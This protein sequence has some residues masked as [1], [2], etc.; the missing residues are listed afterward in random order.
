MMVA[1]A[2]GDER[3]SDSR[4]PV[5]LYTCS[6]PALPSGTA[7]I[8]LASPLHDHAS[9]PECP[10]CATV[11]DIRAKLFDLLQTNPDVA[12]VAV[13]ASAL[14][15]L[16]ATIDRL[17]GAAPATALRDHTIARRFSFAGLVG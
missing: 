15:D 13:D 14:P 1:F 5:T 9:G 4:I 8:R 10:A 2:S 12:A 17:T 11:S 6:L 3:L 7:M 16:S